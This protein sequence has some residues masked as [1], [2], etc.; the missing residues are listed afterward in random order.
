MYIYIGLSL[1]ITLIFTIGLGF[2]FNKFDI[3]DKK[4]IIAITISSGIISILFPFI[5][6]SF[7]ILDS[8]FTAIT[9]FLATLALYSILL[10]LFMIII[11]RF[12][13]IVVCREVNKS[14]YLNN[15]KD[16]GDDEPMSK[17]LNNIKIF[18]TSPKKDFKIT[19]DEIAALLEPDNEEPIIEEKY[20]FIL[21]G[22]NTE[23]EDTN[24]KLSLDI[25]ANTSYSDAPLDTQE[26][27]TSTDITS[28]E[29][30]SEIELYTNLP[31]VVI[32]IEP[33]TDSPEFTFNTN[34]ET[35]TSKLLSEQDTASSC[36]EL[37]PDLSKI[38]MDIEIQFDMD[39][40]LDVDEKQNDLEIILDNDDSVKE[41]VLELELPDNL[42]LLIT[43]AFK[44]KNEG[45]FEI[46][47]QLFSNVLNK[48]P[49]N[50]L[51]FMVILDIC[52]LYKKLGQAV[53][54]KNILESYIVTYGDIMNDD[55][56]N[57][58]IKNLDS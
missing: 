5:L 3:A 51:A 22:D 58:I 8:T 16:K 15:L 26:D 1:S 14:V 17:E 50:D 48:N 23:E 43:E 25:E 10:V 36:E 33:D 9:S 35:T 41:Q 57:E 54:A 31:E 21:E 45:K 52:T 56:K 28:S 18:N 39:E 4:T 20:K 30:L 24:D 12:L 38:D 13:K 37:Q 44:Y 53:L 42:E 47:L 27:I 11:D 7:L 29:L 46:A 32:E 6:R 34:T 2:L 40:I 19:E 49:D 55:I